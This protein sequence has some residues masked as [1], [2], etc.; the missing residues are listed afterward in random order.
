MTKSNRR[1]SWTKN[2]GRRGALALALL[3]LLAGPAGV[4]A[5]RRGH[6][7]P[8][9]AQPQ[10]TAGVVNINAATEAQ[11]ELLPGIGPSKARAIVRYRDRR[12]FKAPHELIRVRGIGRKTFRKLRAHLT[13]TGPTTLTAR[14]RPVKER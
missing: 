10:Q 2:M 9:S 7:R 13:V 1:N 3:G 11:L 8:E 6:K 5:A 14:P 4:Q 12:K